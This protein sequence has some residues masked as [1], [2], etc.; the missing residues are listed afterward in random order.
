[1]EFDYY[2]YKISA[3]F[4]SA[5]I[6]G[7]ESGLTNTEISEIN[8]F[9]D[10]LP[11]KNGHFDLEDYEGESSFSLC[12]ICGLYSD[13]LNFRLYFPLIPATTTC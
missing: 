10:D 2:Q 12:E 1:M 13:C 5:I 8:R 6:N 3:H 9:M 4:A 11:V 7:D